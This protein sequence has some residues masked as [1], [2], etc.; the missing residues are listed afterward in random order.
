MN[1]LMTNQMRTEARWWDFIRST[2]EVFEMEYIESPEFELYF[3]GEI[4]KMKIFV[5]FSNDNGRVCKYMTEHVGGD[6]T[7][8]GE[9]A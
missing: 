7:R 3:D 8:N 6:Y 5:W 1:E 4:K 9:A 2:L